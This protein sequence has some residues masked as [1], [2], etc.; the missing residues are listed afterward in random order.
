MIDRQK[1]D[2]ERG[3]KEE[4]KRKKKPPS[5]SQE[6]KSTLPT[7]HQSVLDARIH[8]ES[9]GLTL[10]EIFI[11]DDFLPPSKKARMANACK[12]N[13]IEQKQGEE[14]GPSESKEREMVSSRKS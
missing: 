8:R 2:I 6:K 4:E 5:S 3:E 14:G 7:H 1:K 10:P 9:S 11:T 13:D 12:K